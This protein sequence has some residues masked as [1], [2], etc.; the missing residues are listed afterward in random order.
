MSAVSQGIKRKSVTAIL[1]SGAEIFLRQAIQLGVSVI[2]ARLLTP[3]E[4]GTVALLYLFSGLAAVFIDGGFSA[5]LIQR[6]E[7]T[8]EDESTV[9]WFNLGMGVLFSLGLWLLAPWIADF[10]EQPI[11]TPLMVVVALTVFCNA[12]S[13]IQSALLSKKLDFKTP[14]KIGVAASIISGTA[15]IILALHGYGV[16]ALV[17]QALIAS[18]V[19][20]LLLW[21]MNDWRPQMVF[22]IVSA[23]RLFRF[24][25]YLMLSG[26]LD[27]AYN[28]IYT[29]LI[30]KFYGVRELG[31]YSRADNTK[32]LPADLLSNVLSRVALP[33]FSVVNQDKD[34]L[35]SGTRHALRGMMMVNVPAML[36]LIVAAKSVVLVLFGAQWLPCVP[37]LQVLC[38]AGLL[39][40]LHVINLTV[41]KALGLSHLFL[42]LEVI[43]KVI[44]IA[45]L[46]GS[47]PYGPIGIAYS[48]VV[49]GVLAFFVNAYYTKKLL[50]YGVLKQTLELLPIIFVSLVM[51]AAIWEL[52]NYLNHVSLS[53]RLSLQV[54]SGVLI[55]LL[56]GTVTKMKA[57]RESLDLLSRRA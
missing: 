38:L 28:R 14:M 5:A 42:R 30:G 31:F 48:Q 41:L 1:W 26:L 34:K 13:S 49:F 20:S 43:K 3:D 12:L 17:I 45:L 39:W 56:L 55:F 27:I 24:G 47:V 46:V 16:W 44:G 54:I 35:R 22:S 19:R 11:L 37:I 21:M 50:N 4:F 23:R 6:N 33:I 36:G 18:V 52:E 53:C 40:P 32:Q 57:F 15:A 29:L 51:A 8:P 7:V 2:L 25:S 10:Y 9:F